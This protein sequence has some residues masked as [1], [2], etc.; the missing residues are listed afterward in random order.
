M[1]VFIYS[2]AKRIIKSCE[3]VVNIWYIVWYF[4][5]MILKEFANRLYEDLAQADYIDAVGLADFHILVSDKDGRRFIIKVQNVP[6]ESEKSLKR[7]EI[8]A[9]FTNKKP[10]D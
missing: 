1:N 5:I 10:A 2:V 6:R 7:K 3:Y 8:F 4:N 9:S